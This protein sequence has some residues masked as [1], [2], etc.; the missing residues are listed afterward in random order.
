M[1]KLVVN[2]GTSVNDKAGDPL[3]TAFNKINLILQI[4]ILNL[5]Q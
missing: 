4:Y 1:A 3:R 2:I 5:I